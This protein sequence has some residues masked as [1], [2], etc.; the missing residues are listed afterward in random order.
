[1]SV[2]KKQ[3][4]VLEQLSNEITSSNTIDNQL[5]SSL[6]V[7]RGLRNAD[8]SGVL[9]G[10]SYISSVVGSKKES[11]QIIPID[12]ILKYR[13]IS[14]GDIAASCTETHLGHFEQFAFYYW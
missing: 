10:L 8:G 2:S 3:L 4:T 14:F 6:S 13:G 11:D 9:A 1:M 7:N 5:Y 12:G